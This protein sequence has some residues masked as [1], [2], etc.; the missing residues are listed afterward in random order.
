MLTTM[1]FLH[2]W[3][4]EITWVTG[5][6]IKEGRELELLRLVQVGTK[7]DMVAEAEVVEIIIL[8]DVEEVES[9]IEEGVEDPTVPISWP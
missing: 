2:Q 9:Q 7:E 8:E 6:I 4:S 1:I 3:Q 5:V